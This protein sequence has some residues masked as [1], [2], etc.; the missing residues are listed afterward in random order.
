MLLPNNESTLEH[1]PGRARW[2]VRH[3]FSPTGLLLAYTIFD[4]VA[5]CL[6]L[7]AKVREAVTEGSIMLSPIRLLEDSLVLLG[8]AIALKIGTRLGILASFGCACW[9]LF[10]GVEA[11]FDIATADDPSAWSLA[12]FKKWW[13]IG[14]GPWDSV[15]QTI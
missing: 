3:F 1:R 5:T 14:P 4:T 2:L 15:R 13:A 11:L 9:I 7:H 6:R 12:A 10:R 8:A